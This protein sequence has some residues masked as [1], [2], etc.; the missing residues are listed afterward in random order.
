MRLSGLLVALFA[1]FAVLLGGNAAR[2]GAF[3][4]LLG[5]LVTAASVLVF[6]ISSDSARCKSKAGNHNRNHLGQLHGMMYRLVYVC[7]LSQQ[8]SP[9]GRPVAQR[10]HTVRL[11]MSI[12]CSVKCEWLGRPVPVQSCSASGSP[13]PCNQLFNRASIAALRSDCLDSADRSCIS[14]GSSFS[15]K[16]YTRRTCG[17]TINFQRP[18]EI[19][20]WVSVK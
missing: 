12:Q 7:C 2:M 19:M 3:F 11:Q 9:M 4:T 14:S 16:S 20:R 8:V 1:D 18:S 15:S 6:L 5:S 13:C 10:F 17:Y